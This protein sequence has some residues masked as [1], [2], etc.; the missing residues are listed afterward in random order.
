MQKVELQAWSKVSIGFVEPDL[1]YTNA[2][3]KIVPKTVPML[4]AKS[5]KLCK[6]SKICWSLLWTSV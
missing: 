6:P 4:Q 1:F 2:K 3:G 5:S